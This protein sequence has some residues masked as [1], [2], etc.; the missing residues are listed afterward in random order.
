MKMN[1][2][3][4]LLPYTTSDGEDTVASLTA[5]DDAGDSEYARMMKRRRRLRK[6]KPHGEIVTGA[7]STD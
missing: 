4:R 1:T 7:V 2:R 3:E 5:S 6:H